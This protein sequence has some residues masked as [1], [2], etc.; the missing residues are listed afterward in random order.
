MNMD[1]TGRV[2]KQAETFTKQSLYSYQRDA[3]QRFTK[4]KQLM[5]DFFALSFNAETKK[6]T[7]IFNNC[8]NNCHT[9]SWLK[10]IVY[11]FR[12]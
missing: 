8:N 5:A 7:N 9:I 2:R 10:L 12:S 4:S 11:D 3:A 6:K 1:I